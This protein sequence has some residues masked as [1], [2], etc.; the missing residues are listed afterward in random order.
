MRYGISSPSNNSRL[1]VA[2]KFLNLNFKPAQSA[3]AVIILTITILMLIILNFI[4]TKVDTI[5]V[6]GSK[7]TAMLKALAFPSF[8]NTVLFLNTL[9]AAENDTRLIDVNDER[10]RA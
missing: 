10:L 1:S 2:S 4:I 3:Y 7:N 6:D 9:Q 8:S 5:T